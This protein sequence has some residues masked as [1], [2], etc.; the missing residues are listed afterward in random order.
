V[1]QY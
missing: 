1:L